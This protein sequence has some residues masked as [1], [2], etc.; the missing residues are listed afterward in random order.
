MRGMRSLPC[1]VFH[2]E[3]M[4]ISSTLS[5]DRHILLAEVFLNGQKLSNIYFARMRH[6][7]PFMRLLSR[8]A[9][10]RS[11]Q[12]KRTPSTQL[13]QTRLFAVVVMFTRH[14]SDVPCLLVDWMNL[15]APLSLNPAS[16]SG[17]LSTC[18][19]FNTLKRREALC[20]QFPV[21]RWILERSI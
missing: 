12:R 11:A 4:K 13:E 16:T 2:L 15:S 10:R 9:I 19:W 20:V 18:T 5:E 1:H 7:M 17:R 3:T 6:G 8:Y 14:S 21:T